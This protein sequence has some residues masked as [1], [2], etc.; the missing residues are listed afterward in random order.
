MRMKKISLFLIFSFLS[1]TLH[2]A[3]KMPILTTVANDNA[4]NSCPGWTIEKTD[5]IQE[6]SCFLV[7]RVTSILKVY[8][9]THECQNNPS[10]SQVAVITINNGTVEEV[11]LSDDKKNET[12]HTQ[13]NALIGA[14]TKKALSGKCSCIKI[15]ETKSDPE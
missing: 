10:S 6:K 3:Q 1:V 5:E 4:S 2:A 11:I 7:G 13:Q 12:T 14:I 15:T 8:T 9:A